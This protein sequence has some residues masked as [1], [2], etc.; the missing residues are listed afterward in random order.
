MNKDSSSYGSPN[1][2]AAPRAWR[3]KVSDG[4]V[5]YFES[6]VEADFYAK[7]AAAC[8]FTVS[9]SPVPLPQDVRAF[10]AFLEDAEKRA[11]VLR[12]AAMASLREENQ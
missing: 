9:T 1:D 4:V 11:G 3:V 12:R 7:D 5:R 2:R 8:G 6:Q 10:V